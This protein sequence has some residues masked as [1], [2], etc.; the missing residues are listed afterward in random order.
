LSIREPFFRR[1]NAVQKNLN[2]KFSARNNT[3]VDGSLK[4]CSVVPRFRC[5][6]STLCLKHWNYHH[7]FK[8]SVSFSLDKKHGIYWK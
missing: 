3:T 8:W 7:T 4:I 5:L 6:Y 1:Q 2:I